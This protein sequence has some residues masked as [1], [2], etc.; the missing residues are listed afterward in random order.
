ITLINK[1]ENANP[2]LAEGTERLEAESGISIIYEFEVGLEGAD[3]AVVATM[4]SGK[5]NDKA[6]AVTA[7]NNVAFLSSLDATLFAASDGIGAF[8]AQEPLRGGFVPFGIAGGRTTSYNNGQKLDLDGFNFIA[9]VGATR[10]TSNGYLHLA[11]FAETGHQTYNA[12]SHFVSGKGNV[13]YMGGGV[14]ARLSLLNGLYAEG[15]I[16]AGSSDIAYDTSDFNVP[17]GYDFSSAYLGGYAGLGYTRTLQERLTWGLHG[18]YIY[19][20]TDGNHAELAGE[21][22]HFEQAS[23][24]TFRVGSSLAYALEN[25]L[26]PY[27]SISWDYTS[28]NKMEAT[29]SGRELEPTDING[30]TGTLQLGLNYTKPESNWSAD[31]SAAGYTGVRDGLAA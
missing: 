30:H 21:D 14:M 8:M 12:S 22:T 24:H 27:G 19:S 28:G 11:G 23:A 9:G 3:N 15:L 5:T 6:N 4:T 26:T 13:N 18:K 29:V 31:L 7:G 17:V 1:T 16:R 20:W 2:D 10:E 25:G